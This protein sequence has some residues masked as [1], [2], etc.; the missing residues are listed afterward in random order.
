MSASC[1]AS[2]SAFAGWPMDPR[3]VT[4]LGRPSLSL[5]MV[6]ATVSSTACRT[7]CASGRS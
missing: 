5:L 2:M 1:E 3:T 7:R 4:E 6:L